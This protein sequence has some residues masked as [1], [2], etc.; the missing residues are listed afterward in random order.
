M[1]LFHIILSDISRNSPP[2]PN[3]R[4]GLDMLAKFRAEG[5]TL[6]VIFYVGNPSLIPAPRR[7]RS[8]SLTGPTFSSTL[9]GDALSRVRSG[10]RFGF[11]QR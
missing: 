8:A 9:V 11:V 3:P 1:R 6:P 2:P 10:S 4:A 7:A 5:A